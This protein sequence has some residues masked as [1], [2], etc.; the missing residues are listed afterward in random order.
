MPVGATHEDD[1]KAGMAFSIA[2]TVGTLLGLLFC[3][4]RASKLLPRNLNIQLQLFKENLTGNGRSAGSQERRGP[5]ALSDDDL[6]GATGID[7]EALD[8]E[9]LREVGD[10]V[11]TYEDEDA[12]AEEHPARVSNEQGRREEE[13]EGEENHAHSTAA[14][15]T[16]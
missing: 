3:F 2:I 6:E 16:S 5:I 15:S 1:P 7:W 12:D 11:E 4:R 8:E 13:G 9:F 10:G 14:T